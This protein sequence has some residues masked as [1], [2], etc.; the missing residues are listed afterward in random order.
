MPSNVNRKMRQ[1]DFRTK[2]K[3]TFTFDIIDLTLY[4][5]LANFDVR[6]YNHSGFDLTRSV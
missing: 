1:I 4:E 3:M 2:Q 5:I 6:T